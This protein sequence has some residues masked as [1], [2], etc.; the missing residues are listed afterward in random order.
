MTKKKFVICLIMFILLISNISFATDLRTIDVGNTVSEVENSNIETELEDG[1][2]PISENEE[3]T[4]YTQ[5]DVC[6]IDKQA[7]ISDLTYGDLYIISEKA[8]ISSDKIEGNAFIIADEVEISGNISGYA[9]II[10]DKIKISGSITGAYII[11]DDVEIDESASILTD[12]KAISKEFNLSGI[13]Y[14]NLS[15][16]SNNITIE[17]NSSNLNIF[18]S[19]NYAGNLNADEELIMGE[20]IKYELPEKQVNPKAET[21]EKITNFVTKM[22]TSLVIIALIIYIFNDKCKYKDIGATEYIK[23]IV[24]G[25]LLLILVPII[26]IGVMF[27]IIGIPIAMLAILFYCLAL[28]IALPVS[29]IKIANIILKQN[30]DSKVKKTLVAFVVSIV[31]EVLTY[32]P[33]IGG[34]IRFLAIL[35]GFEIILKTIFIKNKKNDKEQD[36]ISDEM[37]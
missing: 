37:K 5:G 34:I 22:I 29:S 19:L 7:T 36:V 31:F 6:K 27:T 2:M 4:E 8:I 13:I 28:Y 26:A 16:I 3:I 18:G 21:I 17:R 10:A 35:L 23:D 11:A 33:V 12:I 24:L 32:V 15:I 25:F 9:Y 20:I 1:I 14:R 30:S